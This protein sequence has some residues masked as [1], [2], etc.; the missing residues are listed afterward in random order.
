MSNWKGLYQR[1]V[2]AP[3]VESTTRALRKNWLD[4]VAVD[5]RQAEVAPAVGVCQA[6]V[7]DPQQMQQGRV[8]IVHVDPVL[9]Q[10]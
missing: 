3:S 8:E 10:P 7:I 1:P 9:L 5:V 4:D 6:R 2:P